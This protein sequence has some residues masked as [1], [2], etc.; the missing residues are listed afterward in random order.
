[1]SVQHVR[2]NKQQRLF[3]WLYLLILLISFSP[4]D[5]VAQLLPPLVV[6]TLI[7]LVQVRPRH[8]LARYI[9]I[10][11]FYVGVGTLYQVLFGYFSWINYLLFALTTSSLLVTFYDFRSIADAK[12]L[13]KVADI[14]FYFLL[15]QAAVGFAQ[16]VAAF[17]A[18]GTLDSATGDAVQGTLNLSLVPKA[19]GSNQSYAILVSSMLL[20]MIGCRPRSTARWIGI[21][22]IAFSWLLGSVMHSII[23]LLVSLI[24]V[25]FLFIFFG[26]RAV[27]SAKVKRR[28]LLLFLSALVLFVGFSVVVLPRNVA[29]LERFVDITFDYGP[30]S[31]SQKTVATYN[32]LQLLPLDNPLFVIIG[33]GPGQYSSR[34]SLIRSGEYLQAN[35]PISSYVN[36]YAKKYILDL[37]IR[38]RDQPG[39]LRSS[40]LFPYYSWLTLYGE[41]GILGVAGVLLLIFRVYNGLWEGIFPEFPLLGVCMLILLLYIALLGFQDNYW[42]WTRAIF[43][44]ILLLKLAFSYSQRVKFMSGYVFR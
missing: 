29:S 22:I 41:L 8:H 14:T 35:L 28:V 3:G 6:L 15:I 26:P 39:Y 7:F 42:E 10:G 21:G 36:E 43:P 17:S 24:V 2:L 37:W 30:K 12:L 5:A 25:V 32:T 18:S 23:F 34:A 40:V 31:D 27:I 44:G 38:L 9:V 11:V 20:F 16:V 19:D 4:V 33:V 1:M 13:D